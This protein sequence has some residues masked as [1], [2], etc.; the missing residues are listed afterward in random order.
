MV[1]LAAAMMVLGPVVAEPLGQT[2]VREGAAR[3]RLTPLR[4][5]FESVPIER[6]GLGG[7]GGS[8]DVAGGAACAEVTHVDP[9]IF[10]GGEFA[11]QQGFAEGET[12]YA[13]YA[14]PQDE[15]PIRLE[16]MEAIFAQ[17]TLVNTETQWSL[18]IWDGPPVPGQGIQLWA[19]SSL[20]GLLP[21]LQMPAGLA[22]TNLNVTV[23]PDDPEPI[24][25]NNDSGRNMIS[26]G[27]RIDEHND[28]PADACN[29]VHPFSNAF[30]TTDTDGVDAPTGNYLSALTCPGSPCSGVHSFADLHPD[31]VPSGDWVIRASYACTLVGACCNVDAFCIP[32]LD[33]LS[34]ANQRGIFMGDGS[35]CGE[36]VCPTPVG[37]CCLGSTCLENI[38][39]A[40]CESLSSG[41]YMGN[42]VVCSSS[43]CELGACC[44][45]DGSCLDRVELACDDLGGAWQGGGTACS[46]FRCPQ[47]RGA[48]CI[49]GLCFP[50]QARDTCE[51]VGTFV[52]VNSTCIPDPCDALQCPAGTVVS[53]V[54]P[55]GT[56]DARQPHE[57]D[58][59][60]NPQGI[61]SA[62]EPI[63][64][65]LGVSGAED[66]FELCETATDGVGGNGIVSAVDGGGGVYE[67]VLQRPITAGAATTIR[68]IR[69]NSFVRY[70]SHPA[71]VNGD[72]AANLNDVTALVAV[73]GGGS[74]P[75]HGNH[76]VDLDHSGMPTAADLV[77][78]GD[79]LNGGGSFAVGMGTALPGNGSCP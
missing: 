20:D 1:V 23:D 58:Q 39:E 47:P 17:Q 66:C 67:I 25:V 31:C 46:S 68:Y 57:P 52:G 36:V 48:C 71:N 64:I 5:S 22:A 8:G 33:D 61:G 79:L 62:T 50:K 32:D 28:P 77:R 34:C 53:A 9:A 72:A 59:P 21:P 74:A 18:I 54:P 51:A 27:F 40:L 60:L 42:G 4:V 26:I 6:I 13:V 78:L 65:T 10:S 45:A 11:I 2:G 63:R 70:L 49:E 3:K 76:S 55:H 29:F 75:V 14:V 38:E 19:F 24:L 69:D 43:L 15:F 12:A 56:V 44:F 41:V 73:L 30:P 16:T 37:A 35:S 7:T